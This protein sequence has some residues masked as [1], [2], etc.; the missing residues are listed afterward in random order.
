MRY[1]ITNL[2]TVS[3]AD[4]QAAVSKRMN[5]LSK[6][7]R[8]AQFGSIMGAAAAALDL[9]AVVEYRDGRTWAT[10]LDIGDSEG[11]PAA[12]SLAELGL[13]S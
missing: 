13:V 8:A 4:L 9:R 3:N 6:P 12:F 10:F 2:S 5:P 1:L 7:E 11:P